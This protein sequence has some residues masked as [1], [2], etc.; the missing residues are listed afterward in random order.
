MCVVTADEIPFA[1]AKPT[2][3][4]SWFITSKNFSAIISG[5]VAET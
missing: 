3:A 2:Y 5:T 1:L 4:Y